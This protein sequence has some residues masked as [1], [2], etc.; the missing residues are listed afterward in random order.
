LFFGHLSE[1][2]GHLSPK[3]GQKSKP[4]VSRCPPTVVFMAD[5]YRHGGKKYCNISFRPV[6]RLLPVA[7]LH[8]CNFFLFTAKTV[9]AYP[10]LRYLIIILQI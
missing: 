6:I 4:I 8:G 7:C 10:E 2:F 1:I 9:I 5:D 3:N